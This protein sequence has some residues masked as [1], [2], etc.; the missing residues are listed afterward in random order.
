MAGR[1]TKYNKDILVKALEYTNTGYEEEEPFPTIAGLALALNIARDTVYDWA[2][3]DDKGDFSD[4]VEDLMAKQEIK[5]LSGGIRGNF[6]AS[7]TKLALTKHNY[8]DKQEQNMS[9]AI[10]V[11]D[12]SG[13]TDEELRAIVSGKG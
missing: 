2:K 9:G 8:S 6:N 12:L 11:V 5:L 13:K 1:P 10:G 4:I 7:I 3:Q